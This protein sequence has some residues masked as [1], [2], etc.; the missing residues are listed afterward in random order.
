MQDEDG[1]VWHK[2]TSESFPGMIAPQDDKLPSEVIGTGSA[3]YKSTCATADLAAVAA[4][5]A[6]VYK[7]Y[8]AKFAAQD[9]AAARR[10]WAWAEKN[11]NVTFTNPAGVNTGDYGDSNCS[12]ERAVGR[13]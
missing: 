6:R 5:A 11:P 8:D 3:P 7:P 10:A 2:Q 9:L 1:G 4:I 13:G 12:D